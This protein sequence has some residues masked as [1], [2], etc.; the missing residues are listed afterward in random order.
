MSP[1]E[2]ARLYLELAS[3]S[4][5]QV[6]ATENFTPNSFS[7]MRDQGLLSSVPPCA[8]LVWAS[9]WRVT[10]FTTGC[11]VGGRPAG[12]SGNMVVQPLAWVGLPGISAPSSAASG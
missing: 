3:S 10:V 7:I 1:L 5:A 2:S 9:T 6:Q 11:P 4:V 8:N 12:R